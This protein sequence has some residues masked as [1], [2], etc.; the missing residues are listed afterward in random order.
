MGGAFQ[1]AVVQQRDSAIGMAET[2]QRRFRA[3]DVRS[4]QLAEIGIPRAGEQPKTVQDPLLIHR[5]TLEVPTVAQHLLGQL[6]IEDLDA[7]PQPRSRVRMREATPHERQRCSVLEQMI[8]KQM[9]LQ[10]PLQM[11]RLRADARPQ[12]GGKHRVR[13][14]PLPVA[15]EKQ[16]A[17]VGEPQRRRVRI[18]THL[19]TARTVM[20]DPVKRCPA[21]ISEPQGPQKVVVVQVIAPQQRQRRD[22]PVRG[23]TQ[24]L[25]PVLER[26]RAREEIR[27]VVRPGGWKRW[28][29]HVVRPADLRHPLRHRGAAGSGPVTPQPVDHLRAHLPRT[30]MTNRPQMAPGSGKTQSDSVRSEDSG[31]VVAGILPHRPARARRRYPQMPHECSPDGW[32]ILERKQQSGSIE[33]LSSLLEKNVHSE[34]SALRSGKLP[35]I[36][37]GIKRITYMLI[38]IGRG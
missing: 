6:S 13:Q 21:R 34:L 19:P 28:N 32:R 30:Q 4:N 14:R 22:A 3:L 1:R 12:V 7:G 26:H 35:E 37:Y 18:P 33:L 27:A 31:R 8:A 5:G 23:K 9:P 20:L 11:V 38:N 10:A 25:G 15:A 24:G 29:A 36:L 17:P 2:G 16:R